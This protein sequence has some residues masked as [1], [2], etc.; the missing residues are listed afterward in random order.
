V[1]VS[2]EDI[3]QRKQAE[4]ALRQAKEYTGHIVSAAPTL[5][6]GIAP[7]GTTTSVNQAVGRVTGYSPEEIVGQNWWRFLYPGE[8]YAQVEQLFR[9]FEKGPVVNYEMTLTTKTGERRVISW[10]SVNR[11]DA[12]GKLVEIVGIGAD[13]TERKRTEEV[14]RESEE[15]YRSL[16][17]RMMDGVYRSTHGGRFVDVNPAMVK[18]FGYSSKA[19]LMNVNIT[20]ELYF[21]P[22]ERGSHLLD[23]GQEETEVYRMRRKDGSEI[24]VEDHGRYVH[25]VQGRI[26]FHEGILRDV[27]ERK[28]AEEEIHR[29]NA[30]LERRVIERTKQL[31]AAN[32]ELEAFSYSVSHDLRAPLRGIQ[33]FS[34]ALLED[35][36]D[37]LGAQGKEYLERVRSATQRMEQLIDDMLMLSRVTRS[38]MRREPVD[39]S[40]LAQSIATELQATQP[41]RPGEFSITPGLR[42]NADPNLMRI[43]LENLLGNACK[44]TSKHPTA[45]IEIGAREHEGQTVY[46]VRDDGVGFDMA[47]ADRL[48][49]A[50]QRLH[51]A[52]EFEGTGVGL[53][54]VQR[55]IQRHGGRVWADSAV[56]QGATFY[57]TLEGG[58]NP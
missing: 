21:A 31:Q 4:E 38:V 44:F 15:R 26:A 36:A 20:Q 5:I 42:V 32:S 23:T 52:T 54:I 30:E 10:N 51:A 27:T 58:T 18:M 11:F 46:F 50:F 14:L 39:L 35:C 57:F 29:L 22:E 19:E 3:T 40:G 45:R 48:F 25:D 55:I 8:D 17:D 33:G 47:Y 7:D 34:R 12:E 2:L 13:I 41:G 9:D 56:G 24:W 28:R 6:C 53:A 1:L 16:F 49:S 37:Q 43:V